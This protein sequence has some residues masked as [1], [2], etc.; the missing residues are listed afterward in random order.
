MTLQELQALRLVHQHLLSPVDCLAAA[1]NLCG[2]QA[3]FLNHALHAL[4]LRTHAPSVDGMVKSW[5]L[6]GTMH[7]FPE[8]DC[9]LYFHRQGIPEDVCDTAWYQWCAGRQQANTPQRERFFARLIVEAIAQ[10]VDTRESL[11]L[12][13]RDHG[14]TDEEEARL[15]H[16]WGGV[17]RELAEL[18]L[19]AL[20]VQEEKAYQLL[21]TFPAISERTASVKLMERYLLHYGPVTL[22]DAAYF[23]HASQ[24]Q[25][26]EWLKELPTNSFTIDDRTYFQLQQQDVQT[27]LPD[28]LL[29]AGFDPLM[30][31]YR[32]EDNPFLP[33]EHLRGIFTLTGI[34]H[35]AILLQGRVVGRWK[36]KDGLFSATLFESLA[37]REKGMIG[38]AAE[39]LWTIKRIDWLS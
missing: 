16:S 24:R 17:L 19:I 4:R 28:C 34:V 3:Q 10:G 35:P 15:F 8:E 18:G 31:G 29:L 26:K 12:H 1:R 25:V 9:S 13:C 2:F 36:H 21:P 33:P 6:R 39:K 38:E 27:V 11:R 37:E 5:T 7:L 14:M 30:L 32:K 23:F 22:R 20:K